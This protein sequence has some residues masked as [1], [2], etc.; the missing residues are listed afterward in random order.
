M[1]QHVDIASN[2]S[3]VHLW[4]D[5]LHLPHWLPPG[6]C[7]WQWD[8]PK[9]SLPQAEQTQLS[10]SPPLSCAPGSWTP[11]WPFTGLSQ[12]CSCLSCSGKPRTGHSTPAV[13]SQVLLRGEVSIPSTYWLILP[14]MQFATRMHCWPTCNLLFPK[15]PSSS[16]VKL[17]PSQLAPT[18]INAQSYWVLDAGF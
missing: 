17:L 13:V 4:E 14:C 2:P 8:A 11:W 1:F 7:R 3:T 18:H 16:S 5:R 9:P 15:I 10:A 6:I 12:V